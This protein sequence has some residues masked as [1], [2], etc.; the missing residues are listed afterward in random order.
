MKGFTISNLKK[1]K[2]HCH[3]F[4]MSGQHRIRKQTHS[5]LKN[6]NKQMGPNATSKLLHSKGNNKQ[7]EQTTCILEENICKWCNLQELNFQNIQTANTAQYQKKKPNQK[8][9]RS[10]K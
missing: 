5:Q 3:F 7:N 6:K 1:G 4:Y 9:G 2:H 10:P 8:M